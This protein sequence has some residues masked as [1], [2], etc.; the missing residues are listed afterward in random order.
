MGK[1]EVSSVRKTIVSLVMLLICIMLCGSTISAEEAR[2]V[3]N[4]NSKKF[5]QRTCSSVSKMSESNKSYSNQS[6]AEIIAQG[7]S[8]CS[9][10]RPDLDSSVGEDADDD[11]SNVDNAIENNTPVI[12]PAENDWLDCCWKHENGKSYW[13]EKNKRQGT[14]DDANGVLGQGTVRGR[15]IYDPVSNGWYWLDACYDGAKACNKEVWMPYIY[16]DEDNWGQE[17][18]QQN[19]DASGLM[20]EQVKKAILDKDGKWVR[21]DENGKMYKGWYDADASLYPQQAGNRYYYD[22]KTG[23]MAK[24][25][26]NIDGVDYHFDEI[27]GALIR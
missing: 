27:T 21:Y 17:E 9:I 19:A 16:Q 5:H 25:W 1:N 10:C 26:L 11:N 2:Y 20:S 3:L 15:E 8:P 12:P 7:Y 22:Q 4:K 24:G 13:Y 23:L 14:Y 18:L 6:A